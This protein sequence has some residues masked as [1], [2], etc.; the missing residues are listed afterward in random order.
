MR[1]ERKDPH[2]N[3]I[4]FTGLLQIG[5][6]GACVKNATR[7]IFTRVKEAMKVPAQ[8]STKHRRSVY[9]GFAEGEYRKGV[10]VKSRE[11]RQPYEDF[12]ITIY[13]EDVDP[14]V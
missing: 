10:A 12:L 6:T 4:D 1:V 13:M 2:G 3:A 9:Q 8:I 5:E 14:K 11:R 7:M